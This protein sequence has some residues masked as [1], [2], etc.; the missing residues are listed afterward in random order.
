MLK[1]QGPF[2]LCFA[3]RDSH[4]HQPQKYTWTQENDDEPSL[5][6][7]LAIFAMS[8]VH[9]EEGRPI[10]LHFRL[11]F[12]KNIITGSI[13]AI[14][15]AAIPLLPRSSICNNR[16]CSR[17]LPNLICI[18]TYT[19]ECE[20]KSRLCIMQELYWLCMAHASIS[21]YSAMVYGK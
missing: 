14:R 20:S 13:F 6:R 4:H 5:H 17:T 16:N 3:V 9:R 11:W 8:L 19:Y 21:V 18:P 2:D 12:Y 7:L 15:N 10:T 1:P